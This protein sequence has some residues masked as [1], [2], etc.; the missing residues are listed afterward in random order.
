MAIFSKAVDIACDLIDAGA[1]ISARLAD[2]RGPLHLAAQYDQLQVIQKLLERNAKNVA[3]T[4]RKEKGEDEDAMDSQ[5]EHPERPSSEDDWSSHED[6]DVDMS[7]ADEA[8]EDEDG[9][10]DDG[11]KSKSKKKAEP[12]ASQVES[13]DIPEEEED[14]PDI[15]VIDELDWDLGFSALSYAIL[16]A[17]LPTLEALLAAGAD[18]NV[19][20]KSNNVPDGRFQP[21]SL[22]ILRE[23]EDEACIVAERL[24][25][26]GASSST[27]DDQMRTILHVAVDSGRTKLVET[28]L[29]CDPN[30]KK[31]VNFPAL[32]AQN[33]VF[34]I[35]TA[36]NK[37]YY[38]LVALLLAHDA[39]LDLDEKDITPAQEAAYVLLLLL[40]MAGRLTQR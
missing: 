15:I 32:V 1:R 7:D 22:C 37:K 35:V 30:A 40:D 21:L 13:G 14:Q 3:D 38:G 10:D 19:V 16:F 8:D 18:I 36:I 4:E 5:D 34:P 11:K 26:A 23:D 31:V 24:I 39:K 29:K 12:E 20:T 6:D 33:V 17:S 27:A 9:D 28:L 25:K 2:G